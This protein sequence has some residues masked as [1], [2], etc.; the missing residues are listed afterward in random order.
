MSDNKS[1]S[2]TTAKKKSGFNVPHILI[3]ITLVILISCLLTYIA[4]TGVYEMDANNQAIA[5]SYHLV[6]RKP[7]SPWKALLM[8]KRGIESASSIISLMLVAGGAI[9][10]IIE[11]GAF[12]DILNYGVYKLQDK[13]VTV[14]V[15]AIVVMMSLLGAFAG[16][17]SMIAFVTVGIVICKKLRLD[18]IVAM[19]MFYLGYLLGQGASFTSNMII[20]FQQLCD[21]QPLSGMTVRALTLVIFTIVHAVY[22][23]R[24][25][26][27]IS[28]DPNKSFVGGVLEPDSDMQEIESASFPMRGIIV[29]LVM[30]GVYVF[31][32]LAAQAWGWGQEYLAAIIILN[33][34]FSYIIVYGKK[35]NEMGK[36][37]FKG[38]QNMGGICLVMGLARVVGFV[39]SEGNVIHTI[40]A[41]VAS[42]LGDSGLAMAGIGIFLFTLFFNLFI[43]SGT[44]KAA[45]MMPV[46]TPI[47]DVCGLTRQV[48]A[49]AYQMGDSLTNTL[50]PMSG[51]LTGSL[52]L[53]DVDYVQWIKYSAPLMGILASIAGVMIAILSSISWVG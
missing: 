39:L 21:V 12:T 13:S 14:L 41:A 48:V 2:S 10:C 17:D 26:M 19:S 49:F 18:R 52:G 25:A 8:V 51:P 15:P 29:A 33:A 34:I 16:G 40:S 28:K 53:A 38:A 3:I 27:K 35:A 24:Y 45:I 5:G 42:L 23:T 30:F 31:Y 44:S 50:T 37:F 22:L 9:S 7:I 46:L 1:A 32:A 43:P 36:T 11:T 6:E 4:P 20:I 47:G